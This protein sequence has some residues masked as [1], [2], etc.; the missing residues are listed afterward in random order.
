MCSL[1]RIT[2]CYGILGTRARDAKGKDKRGLS[3]KVVLFPV[4][5]DIEKE[6][7]DEASRKGV[8]RT[9]SGDH[10]NGPD[11]GRISGRPLECSSR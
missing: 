11:L 1:A 2:A 7:R 8:S 6:G 9:F 5:L 4:F 3:K 10:T